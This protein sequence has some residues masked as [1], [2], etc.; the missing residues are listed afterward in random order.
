[1]NIKK[2]NQKIS[3]YLNYIRMNGHNNNRL[4]H[5]NFAKRLEDKIKIG[6]LEITQSNS[7]LKSIASF[8]LLP[9]S[10][11][12]GTC[13]NATSLCRKFCYVNGHN[14]LNRKLSE[15]LRL[16]LN[17]YLIRHLPHREIKNQLIKFFKSYQGNYFR[18]HYAGDFF[19]QWYVDL[20]YSVIKQFP[21]IKF[22][23]FTKSHSLD[24]SNKPNNLSLV[25]SVF[26]DTKKIIDDIPL[27]I[28]IFPSGYVFNDSMYNHSQEI[29][30]RA[31]DAL[32]CPGNCET[33]LAC[34]G[35][36]EKHID[37]KFHIHGAVMST[38]TR[39]NLVKFN[40]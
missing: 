11:C 9:S 13:I 32:M 29:A 2:E 17:T 38:Y 5:Q 8:G 10:N 40:D 23:A 7:K 19:A 21:R 20:W 22:L 28:A 16:E 4:N 15:R 26:P 39:F 3:G 1:M 30:I 6:K 25:Y 37:V 27:S 18:I 35:L 31:M 34:F 36:A 24:F 33:C 14:E 12:H